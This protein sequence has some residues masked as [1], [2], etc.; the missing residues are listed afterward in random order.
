M[1]IS[2]IVLTG[3]PCAGKSTAM[4]WIQNEFEQKGYTVL[5][6]SET[7]T[8]L[9][10]GGITP[11]GCKNVDEFQKYVMKTIFI[12][13]AMIYKKHAKLIISR[14]IYIILILF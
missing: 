8:E 13:G 2:K 6:V 3:G 7:A 10:L 11:W 4:S 1:K 5:F 9:I 14:Y 12:F